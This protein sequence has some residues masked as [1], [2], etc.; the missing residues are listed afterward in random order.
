MVPLEALGIRQLRKL[1]IPEAAG[2]VLELGAGT[3]ANLQW[4]DF[5][6]VTS[7][8]LSDIEISGLLRKRG[9]AI[10]ADLA[11][12]NV[13]NLPFEDHSFDTVVF[14][15]LFCS[16]PQ[17]MSGLEEIRRVLKPGGRIIFLEHVLGCSAV[18]KG[19]QHAVTPLW[20][21]MAGNCHLD[22]PTADYIKSAGFTLER[23]RQEGGCVLIGGIAQIKADFR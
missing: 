20:R 19:F 12:A 2:K 10:G 7:L 22:R 6:R 9:E 1:H 17:P 13:E 23:Y 3:G 8:T 21:K 4:Y 14:T 16:V 5:S 18:T 11:A 15:L